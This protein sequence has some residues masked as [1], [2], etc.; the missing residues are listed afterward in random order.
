[1]S[2]KLRSIKVQVILWGAQRLSAL[3]LALCVLVHLATIIYAVRSGLTAAHIV[4]RL[5]QSSLWTVFYSLF[6]L[7]IAIHAPIGLRTVVAE[8]GYQG[9]IID[10]LLGTIALALVVGGF[11]ALF[12]LQGL[13]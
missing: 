2:C 8:W 9:R 5:H 4:S 10:G 1:M 12:A 11:R 3:V 6:V 13:A 7:A